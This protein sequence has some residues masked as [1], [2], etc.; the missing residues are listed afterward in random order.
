LLRLFKLTT[1]GGFYPGYYGY[2]YSPYCYSGAEY[3]TKD[4]CL[5]AAPAAFTLPTAT[6][7]ARLRP[8]IAALTEIT[9]QRAEELSDSAS[10]SVS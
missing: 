9:H 4:T 5:V 6:W 7:R 10:S 8:A 2:G 3:I 1:L